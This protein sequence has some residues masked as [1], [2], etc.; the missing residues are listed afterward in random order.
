MFSES[1]KPQLSNKLTLLLAIFLISCTKATLDEELP[2]NAPAANANLVVRIAKNQLTATRLNFVVYDEGTRVKQ[3]N[4]QSSAADFGS[5]VFQLKPGTYRLVVLAHSSNGNPTMT[6]PAKI[7]FKNNQGFTDTFLYDTTITV[8]EESQTLNVTPNRI[9]ALCRFV[10][11]DAIPEGVTQMQFYYTGGSGAFNATTGLG[12]VNSKQQMK[13]DVSAGQEHT[14]YDLYTFLHQQEG[15]IKLIA[16]ALDAAGET[17]RAWEFAIPLAQ[18]QITWTTGNFFA[19]QPDDWTII[20][21][22]AI[23]HSWASHQYLEY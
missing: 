9:V 18:N 14:I 6:D 19:D 11:N 2:D 1:H 12:C 17:Q 16:S 23:D 5:A 15:T 3:I 13:F 10:I 20:P 8:G 22:T 4:Q 7:Q 21:T